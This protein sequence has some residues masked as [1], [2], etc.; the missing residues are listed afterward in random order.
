MSER[1][2]TV[3][4]GTTRELLARAAEEWNSGQLYEAHETLEEVATAL[5]EDDREYELAL[6]LV[7]ASACLHKLIYDVGKTAVPSKLGRALEVLARAPSPWRG[8]DVA[9]LRREL[10]AL[11]DELASEGVGRSF[12]A[13]TLP[14]FPYDG[15]AH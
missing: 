13:K 15:S 6:A 12:D 8:L 11:G 14:R 10:A 7:H 1:E 5:E 4:E 3:T 2:A 9:R